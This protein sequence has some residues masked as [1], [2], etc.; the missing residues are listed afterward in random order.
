MTLLIAG[1]GNKIFLGLREINGMAERSWLKEFCERKLGSE[2]ILVFR[3]LE[4]VVQY[5]YDNS[6]KNFG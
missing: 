3:Q 1:F 6:S 4:P 5:E 2:K